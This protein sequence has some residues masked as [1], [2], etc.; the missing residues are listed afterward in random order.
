[1]RVPPALGDNEYKKMLSDA[2]ESVENIT[3]EDIKASKVLGG[4]LGAAM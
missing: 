2:G 1:M 3:V 4:I